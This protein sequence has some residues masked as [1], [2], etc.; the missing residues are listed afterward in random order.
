M[1]IITDTMLDGL[2]YVQN[3]IEP[4]FAAEIIEYLNKQEW[5]GISASTNGRKVQQYG[6]EYNYT[7]R[8]DSNYKKIQDIPEILLILKNIAIDTIDRIDQKIFNLETIHKLNQCIINK[9]EPTQGISAH[10][11]KETFGPVIACFSLGSGTTIKFTRTLNGQ[12]VI[13]NKYVEPNS[14]YIMTGDSRYEWK[15][16]I[17]PRLADDKVRRTTR[18]SVT[19]RSVN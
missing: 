18:I 3:I 10:I 8:Q 2:F 15:H 19:F 14:I 4:D 7:T 16:E 6:Y 11:D 17:N 9:Y 1:E 13:V 5:K 12:K